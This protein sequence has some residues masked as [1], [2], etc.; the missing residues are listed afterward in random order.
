MSK[1]S[2]ASSSEGMS[3]GRILTAKSCVP[4][5]NDGFASKSSAHGSY[6]GVSANLRPW[7]EI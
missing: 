1:R 4:G 5:T 6:A 7:A 3:S 2:N